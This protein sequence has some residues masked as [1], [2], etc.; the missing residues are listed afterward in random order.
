MANKK[1]AVDEFLAVFDENIAALKA[2]R[3]LAYDD[4]K[5]GYPE[6]YKDFLEYH[7]EMQRLKAERAKILAP[8]KGEE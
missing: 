5:E 7:R 1:C 3:D 8:F 4:S 2:L 6:R